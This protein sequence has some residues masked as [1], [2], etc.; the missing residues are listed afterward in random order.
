[1]ARRLRARGARSPD[2]SFRLVSDGLHRSPVGLHR[3]SNHDAPRAD[4]PRPRATMMRAHL[5]EWAHERFPLANGVFFVLLYVLALVVGRSVVSGPIVLSW[6]DLPG[7][8]A[9][10]SFFLWL[11]VLDE[12]KDF[13]ND[14]VAHPQRVLQ[15]GLVTL[16]DLR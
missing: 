9:L 4:R 3:T 13:E 16:G 2:Q 10:W 11:R 6:H 5:A 8:A 14:R 7:V 1:M 15:R 12:H